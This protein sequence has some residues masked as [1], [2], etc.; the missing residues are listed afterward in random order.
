MTNDIAIFI[1]ALHRIRRVIVAVVIA[2]L[3]GAIALYAGASV[4]GMLIVYTLALV[5]GAHEL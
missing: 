1:T 3:V 5:I 4:V 2:V